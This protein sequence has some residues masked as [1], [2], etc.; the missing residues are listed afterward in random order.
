MNFNFINLKFL[1][2]ALKPYQDKKGNCRLTYRR[3]GQKKYGNIN[4]AEK[5][6]NKVLPKMEV[7]KGIE[8]VFIEK[9][10]KGGDWERE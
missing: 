8:E 9:K 2:K 1:K 5:W 4:L 7:V 6:V 3:A 10:N